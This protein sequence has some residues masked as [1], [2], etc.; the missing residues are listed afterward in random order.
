LAEAAVSHE[1][2]VYAWLTPKA[3]SAQPD[4]EEIWGAVRASSDSD[5]NYCSKARV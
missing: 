3:Q 2:G 4:D 5:R 1:A